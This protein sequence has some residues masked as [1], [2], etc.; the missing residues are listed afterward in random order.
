MELILALQTDQWWEDVTLPVLE[1]VRAKLRDLIKFTDTKT[2]TNDVFTDF[3]DRLIK[4]DTA[5]YS[6]VKTDRSLQDYRVRV[7][8]IIRDHKDHITIR[9]LKNNEPVS[10]ADISALEKMLFAD[11]GGVPK[12]DYE[13]NY[14]DK[15]VGLLVRSIVGLNRNAAK[16]AFAEFLEKSPLHPDQISF[17]N[18]VVE[19]LVQNGVM[20]PKEMFDAPFTHYHHMGLS[21]VMGEKVAKKVVKLVKKINKN[22][23]GVDSRGGLESSI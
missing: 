3:E 9:R 20:E 17:L 1:E 2:Q 5:E 15:P 7:E 12:K 14:G 18:E 21:G 8:K 10:G 22:A 11:G 16:Q 19:Y 23:L 13:A 6:V 4:E